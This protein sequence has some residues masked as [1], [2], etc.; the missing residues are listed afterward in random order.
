MTINLDEFYW[1]KDIKSAI[2]K[3]NKNKYEELNSNES[4]IIY[5]LLEK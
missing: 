1:S 2:K 5:G 3:Y 4:N